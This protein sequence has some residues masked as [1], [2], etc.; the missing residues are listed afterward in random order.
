MQSPRALVAQSS[1][2]ANSNLAHGI[3]AKPGVDPVIGLLS[4]ENVCN[5]GTSPSIFYM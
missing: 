3:T 5:A 2:I 4:R 1:V